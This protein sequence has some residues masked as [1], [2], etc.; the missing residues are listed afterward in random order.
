MSY[1]RFSVTVLV[2]FFNVT[3]LPVVLAAKQR[4]VEIRWD[5]YAEPPKQLEVWVDCIRKADQ[6]FSICDDEMKK[7]K[8][9]ASYAFQ[10]KSNDVVTLVLTYDKTDGTDDVTAAVTGTKLDDKD[11]EAL[12]KI[13]GATPPTPEQERGSRSFGGQGTTT[14]IRQVTDDLIAGGKLTVTYNIKRKEN[15]QERIV[16][17]SGA[18]TFKIATMSPRLTVSYGSALSQATNSTLTIAK[19]STLITFVKNGQ[20]QQAYQQVIA[21]KDFDTSLKPIQA[22]MTLGNFRIWSRVYASIGVQLNQKLFEQPFLGGT[23][24]HPLGSRIAFNTTLGVQFSRETEIIPESGFTIGQL[25][26]PTVGLTVDD[27]PTRQRYHRR[28]GIAF[29]IDF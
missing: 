15:N 28:F 24:R 9:P 1:K 19:T 5:F 23:Y 2:L 6:V 22:L 18:L 8:A 29:S 13:F 27:I 21:H 25:V 11:L 14:V 16:K 20:T 12:K 10:L 7:T 26:D 3:C 17:T 4:N